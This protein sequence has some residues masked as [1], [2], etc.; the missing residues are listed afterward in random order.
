M[1]AKNIKKHLKYKI[2]EWLS[3]IG[4]D[5]IKC[6]VEKNIL[7]TGGCIVSL[8]QNEDINDYDIYFKNKESAYKVAEYYASKF[9]KT[10][11]TVISISDEDGKIKCFINSDGVDSEDNHP[12]PNK[13]DKY[14]PVYLTSNAITLSDKIQLIIRFFGEHDQIH[15]NF[16]FVHCK[17]F[18]DYYKNE[19]ILPSRSLEA[20]INKELYYTG[21]LYPIC[22]IIRARKFI[23]RGWSINAG[24]YLKMSFQISDLD[25]YNIDTLKEQLVGVDAAYFNK[26]IEIMD[27]WKEKNNGV[28]FEQEYLFEIINKIF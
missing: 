19:L 7:V 21:S 1:I 16:D 10:H 9:N 11:C 27:A 28:N 20:I 18:Y 24:Q 13:E 6:I 14:R 5:N 25:L 4:D 2:K 23:K 8:L 26:I 22:S 3:T 17:C 12:E 15:E